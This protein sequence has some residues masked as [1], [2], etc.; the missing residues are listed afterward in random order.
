MISVSAA[1]E[2]T[3]GMKEIRYLHRQVSKEEVLWLANRM[4]YYQL[5]FPTK[6]LMPAEISDIKMF[7]SFDNEDR[8][9]K[10][11]K[12]VKDVGKT[13]KNYFLV[14]WKTRYWVENGVHKALIP[15]R[16]FIS[17]VEMEEKAP[18]IISSFYLG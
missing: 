10:I 1:D 7:G 6:L 11:I 17:E 14:E 3:T 2:G 5:D 18:E 16:N 4:F 13:M 9:D 8:P 12:I 15:H